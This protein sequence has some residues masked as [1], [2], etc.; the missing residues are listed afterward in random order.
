[1]TP[2]PGTVYGPDD[3]EN[4]DLSSW[5]S[6]KAPKEYWNQNPTGTKSTDV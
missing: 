6:E 5:L 3:W 2:L 4:A 1:M